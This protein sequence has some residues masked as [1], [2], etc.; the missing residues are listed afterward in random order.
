[1]AVLPVPGGL[2]AARRMLSTGLPTVRSL[3]TPRITLPGM[4]W[5]CHVVSS[6][7]MLRDHAPER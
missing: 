3:V 2:S 7:R 5:M 6:I 1:M 4:L